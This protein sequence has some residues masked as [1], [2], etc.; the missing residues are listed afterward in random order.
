MGIH[1]CDSPRFGQTEYS[2][3]IVCIDTANGEKVTLI[4]LELIQGDGHGQQ[5]GLHIAD[6][7]PRICGGLIDRFLIGI[8][9]VRNTLGK[10]RT[11]VLQRPRDDNARFVQI[12][13]NYGTRWR[14]FPFRVE[15][16][17]RRQWQ[18]CRMCLT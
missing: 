5:H 3:A 7:S 2:I 11:R 18:R 10:S 6:M 1:R 4:L 8:D 17:W 14:Q 16:L 9:L 15:L 12:D 13:A